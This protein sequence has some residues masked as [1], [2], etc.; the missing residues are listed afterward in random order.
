[1]YKSNEMLNMLI[2]IY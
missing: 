2:L 1:V